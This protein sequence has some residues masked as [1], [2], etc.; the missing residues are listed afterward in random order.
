MYFYINKIVTLSLGIYR[1]NSFGLFNLNIYLFF[2]G[3][4]FVVIVISV[5]WIGLNWI[6]SLFLS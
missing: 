4:K 6:I 5:G 1:G 3:L 2:Y